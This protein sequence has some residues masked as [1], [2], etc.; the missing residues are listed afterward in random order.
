M[1]DHS[2]AYEPLGAGTDPVA[3]S[4][5]YV[6]HPTVLFPWLACAALSAFLRDHPQVESASATP[7]P[8][9]PVVVSTPRRIDRE[10]SRHGD[11]D[12]EARAA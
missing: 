1:I 4:W 10:P 12:D 9:R 3:W 11:S 6:R 7:L 8:R 5:S 2:N